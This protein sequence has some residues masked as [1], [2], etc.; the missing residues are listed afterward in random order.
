MGC[1]PLQGS[2]LTLPCEDVKAICPPLYT[3]AQRA[4]L[5][6]KSLGYL[7]VSPKG[8]RE[9]LTASAM[10]VIHEKISWPGLITCLQIFPQSFSVL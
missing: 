8:W 4:L 2:G 6:N 7:V 9:P 1:G 10:D 3:R 5:L